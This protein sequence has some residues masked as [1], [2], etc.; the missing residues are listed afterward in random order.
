MAILFHYVKYYFKK[1]DC[2]GTLQGIFAPK[3]VELITQKNIAF[4][5][6]GIKK[7]GLII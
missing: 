2:S 3:N 6:M 4:G 5:L 7:S 1:C